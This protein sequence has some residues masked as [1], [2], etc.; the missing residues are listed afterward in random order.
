LAVG[1][2]VFVKIYGTSAQYKETYTMPRNL[3]NNSENTEFTT[4]TL[5]QV[6]NHLIEIGNNLLDLV[7]EPAGSNNFRDLNYN[8][9]GGKLLQHSASMRPAALLFANRDVDPVQFIRYAADS[10]NIFK[11]QLLN[12]IT[13][14]EF[15]NP[16][17]YRDSLDMV[18]EEFSKVANIGQPFYYTDMIG[19]GTDYIKNS[20]TVA[21]TTY[22]SY[23]LTQ[24]FADDTKGYRS[25]L[26][27]LNG[28][29]L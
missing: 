2:R 28:V 5:G 25:L 14:T 11:N 3:T 29:L 22:R 21:N 17:S 9:V 1:D 13:N 24:D 20:Y 8:Y 6:R 27:Y 7:G 10:Y 18:L 26:V 12:Y 23:N 16:T 15:P 4:I 19:F